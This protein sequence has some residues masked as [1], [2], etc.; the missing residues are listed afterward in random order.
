MTIGDVIKQIAAGWPAYH[1]KAQV[2]RQEPVYDLVTMQFPE[3]LRTHVADFTY[4]VEEGSTGRGNQT[5]A[6]W[7]ALFDRR[8]TTSATKEYY[9]VYL[10]SIDMSTVT[11]ALAFGTTQFKRQFGSY[12]KAFPR[13]RQAATRLQETF[14]HLIPADLG[15]SPIDLAADPRQELHYAYQQSS[16]LSFPPYRIGA[17]PDER[18][19]VSDLKQLVQLYTEIVSDPLEATVD[20][21]VEAVVDPAPGL[22]VPEVRDFEPRPPRPDRESEGLPGRKRRY[23]PESRKVGDAGEQVVL[24]YE[25]NRLTN[26]GRLDLADR[27]QWHAKELDFVGWDI[28]SFDPDGTEIFVEVKS[29]VGKSISAVN[30]TVN[31]WD[32]ARDPARRDRYY[33][34]VVTSALSDKPIIERMQNPASYVDRGELICE[35]V[36]Y[37]LQLRQAQTIKTPSDDSAEIVAAP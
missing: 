35:S 20:R 9:V 21:L 19:L 15:R 3:V 33:I 11:L 5:P 2:D 6:P 26:L 34:Y 27:I 30:L 36:V 10:F 16:I 13:M 4:I 18:K 37:E 8:L 12:A 17:L 32:A 14:N 28:S 29:S 1:Q 22:Q 23:S 24:T 25:K 31:E 7:I